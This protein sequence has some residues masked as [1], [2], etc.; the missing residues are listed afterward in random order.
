MNKKF[1]RGILI[2]IV[3]AII[4][5]FTAIKIFDLTGNSVKNTPIQTGEIK[6]FKVEAYRF[7]Y[8]PD[9]I[10]VNRG[11]RVR[12]T[13]VNTDTLHGI[14]IPEIGVSGDDVVEFVAD[15]SGK[16]IWY[17]KNMCGSEHKSMNGKLI[18]KQD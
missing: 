8:T 11:D 6:E 10:I 16:F 18:V 17:C 14:K 13:I 3:I 2:L 7:G 12:I 9:N 1:G 5:S 4:F 15:K